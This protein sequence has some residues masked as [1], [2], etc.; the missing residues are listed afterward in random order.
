[1]RKAIFHTTENFY[2]AFFA[3]LVVVFGFFGFFMT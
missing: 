1:M 3:S 2:E